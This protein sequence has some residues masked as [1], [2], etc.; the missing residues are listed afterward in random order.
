MREDMERILLTEADIPVSY[1][2]LNVL[3]CKNPRCITSVEPD[4]P[5]IF[6]L[7]SPETHTYRCI[8][9]EMCIRDSVNAMQAA[10]DAGAKV[11]VCAGFLQETALRT[12]A[13]NLSLIHIW[14]LNFTA[15]RG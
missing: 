1:T 6:R 2:H 10:V 13:M 7:T 12:A 15:R 4:L 11:V 9:C 5:Q 8:Y 3:R 14:K